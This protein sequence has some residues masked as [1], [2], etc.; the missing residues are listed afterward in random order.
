MEKRLAQMN[1]EKV[2]NS[3]LAS[4]FGSWGFTRRCVRV[5]AFANFVGRRQVERKPDRR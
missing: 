4:D 2:M 1:R 5:I 3:L